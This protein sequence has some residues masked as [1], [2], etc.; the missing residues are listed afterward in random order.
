CVGRAH[1]ASVVEV[2]GYG[3]RQ[4]GWDSGEQLHILHVLHRPVCVS[5]EILEHSH[6]KKVLAF[7]QLWPDDFISCYRRGSVAFCHLVLLLKQDAVEGIR[8]F[9]LSIVNPSHANEASA[10]TFL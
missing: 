9:L 4:T 3:R 1:N 7:C 8:L 2:V 5:Y 10:K 6:V